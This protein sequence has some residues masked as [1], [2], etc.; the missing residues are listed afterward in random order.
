MK[1]SILPTMALASQV[2]WLDAYQLSHFG[3]AADRTSD[4]VD[5]LH[6]Q[7]KTLPSA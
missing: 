2:D 4:V 5:Q 1:T 6:E 7:Q 3:S